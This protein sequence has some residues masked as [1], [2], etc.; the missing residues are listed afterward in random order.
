VEERLMCR[1]VCNGECATGAFGPADVAYGVG[2]SLWWLTR[3]VAAPTLLVA[4][5]TAWRW[6]TGAAMLP[7]MPR[8]ARPQWLARLR[9]S[10]WPRWQ[11]AVTR[12]VLTAVV[13]AAWIAPLATILTV[14]AVATG[15]T[16]AAVVVRRRAATGDRAA[17]PY[18]ADR[19]AITADPIRVD[20]VRG[21]ASQTPVRR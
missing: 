5:V 19:A 9:W 15:T 10:Q 4:G 13:V 17:I 8:L 14:A 16:F 7:D 11:R 6:F 3:R 20:S 2:A 21:I 1:V 12:T 18:R